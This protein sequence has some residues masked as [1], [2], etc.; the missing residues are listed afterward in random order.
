MTESFVRGVCQSILVFLMSLTPGRE[1]SRQQDERDPFLAK[2]ALAIDRAGDRLLGNQTNR[3][4]WEQGGKRG[5]ADDEVIGTTSLCALALYETRP[6]AERL[7]HVK[8]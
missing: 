1:C 2:V 8:K 7:P 3:G 5:P 4:T 6:R